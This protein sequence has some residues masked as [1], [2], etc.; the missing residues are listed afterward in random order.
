MDLL[1]QC[2]KEYNKRQFKI[3]FD[4]NF[5]MTLNKVLKAIAFLFVV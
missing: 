1:Q 5:L 2:H 3:L 4:N